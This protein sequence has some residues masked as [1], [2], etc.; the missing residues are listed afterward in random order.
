MWHARVA[1]GQVYEC[2]DSFMGDTGKCAPRC[3]GGFACSAPFR[4][5]PLAR[6]TRRSSGP[7]PGSGR[8]SDPNKQT[9]TISALGS[10]TTR[11]CFRYQR[12]ASCVE[13]YAPLLSSHICAGPITHLH[14]DLTATRSLLRTSVPGLDRLTPAHICAGIRSRRPV[15][16]RS[17]EPSGTGCISARGAPAR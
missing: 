13:T 7:E 6:N 12:F 1:W 8:K 4:S 10:Q 14:R 15:S 11:R 5:A 17:R 2:L 3:R 9:P 16:E